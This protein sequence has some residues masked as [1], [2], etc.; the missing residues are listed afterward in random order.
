MSTYQEVMKQINELQKQAEILRRQELAEVIRDIK[1]KIIE[2]NLT[3][4]ELGL[5]AKTAP[6][7]GKTVA[8]KYC[9]PATGETWTGRGRMPKWLQAA[10]SQGRKK[11][12]FLI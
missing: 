1:A 11:E 10:E 7:T 2:F 5:S 3:A 12:D 8:A 6:Q 9:N 4:A